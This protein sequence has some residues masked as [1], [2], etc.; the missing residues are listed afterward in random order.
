MSTTMVMKEQKLLLQS[1]K[2]NHEEDWS[3]TSSKS[4]PKL[5]EIVHASF[6]HSSESISGADQ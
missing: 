3:Y 1:N 6:S 2:W 5:I 4:I